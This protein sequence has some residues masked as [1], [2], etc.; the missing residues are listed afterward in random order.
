LNENVY[1]IE[2]TQQDGEFTLTVNG[3]AVTDKRVEL[4]QV[5]SEP[6][7]EK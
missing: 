1:N 7:H 3:L 2:V 4:D 6:I 5:V